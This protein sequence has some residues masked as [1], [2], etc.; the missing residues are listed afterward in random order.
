MQQYP[1][2]AHV[3]VAKGQLTAMNRPV[4]E[5]DPAAYQRMKYEL[6]SR[7]KPGIVHRAISPFEAHPDVYMAAKTGAPMMESIRPSVPVSVPAVAA[8]GPERHQRRRG[9]RRRRYP[10]IR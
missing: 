1:L 2:G 3:Q 4:P 10:V 9:E 8:G 7:K 6:A 5:A